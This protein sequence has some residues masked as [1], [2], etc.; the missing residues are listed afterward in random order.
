MARKHLTIRGGERFGRLDLGE[1]TIRVRTGRATV[2][3]DAPLASKIRYK[4]RRKG[5][6]LQSRGK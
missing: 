6:P 3:I 4:E 2:T 1:Y 5:K